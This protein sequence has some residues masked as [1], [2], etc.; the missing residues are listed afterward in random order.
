[1]GTRKVARKAAFVKSPVT[2]GAAPLPHI[3]LEIASSQGDVDEAII[4]IAS[5]RS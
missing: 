3:P 1:V 5:W 4:Y 2:R